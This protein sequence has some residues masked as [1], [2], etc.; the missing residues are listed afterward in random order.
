MPTLRLAYALESKRRMMRAGYLPPLDQSTSY[1]VTHGQDYEALGANGHRTAING[2][3]GYEGR[4]VITNMDGVALTEQT[5][6]RW[7]AARV[8][9]PGEPVGVPPYQDHRQAAGGAFNGDASLGMI[10]QK[11]ERLGAQT[12]PGLAAET[13]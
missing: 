6:A 1:T 4:G 12:Y 3:G 7:R 9:A 11:I 10:P 5:A 13:I 8:S 2:T